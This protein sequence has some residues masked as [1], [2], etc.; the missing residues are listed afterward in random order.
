MAGC[1]QMAEELG[2]LKEGT[3]EGIY[4]SQVQEVK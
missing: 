2:L 1:C 3:R 4:L